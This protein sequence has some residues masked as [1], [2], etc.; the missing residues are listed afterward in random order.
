MSIGNTLGMLRAAAAGGY[1]VGAFQC[2]NMESVKAVTEVAEEL[3]APVILAIGPLEIDYAGID[4]LVGV[5]HFHA[6]RATVPVAIHLDHG[7]SYDMACDAVRCRF[8]SVMIDA[9]TL[10]YAENAAVTRRVVQMAHSQKVPVEGELGR[11]GVPEGGGSGP[12]DPEAYQTDPDEAL[13]FVKDTG[14]DSL[15]VAIGNAHGFYR[16]KPDINSR[17]L[18]EIRKRL[19]DIPIVLHGGT[20][21]PRDTIEQT[22]TEGIAKINIATEYMHAFG[23]SLVEALQPM[24]EPVNVANLFG[25]TLERPRELVRKKIRLFQSD[26]KA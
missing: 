9:S 7:D 2:W 19:P 13:Q 25:G 10:P 11:L 5:A 17:R 23:T 4:A 8:S 14:V 21:I 26:G 16:G 20:G 1:A 24:R 18:R 15:A 12:V 3:R 22:L 6:Q